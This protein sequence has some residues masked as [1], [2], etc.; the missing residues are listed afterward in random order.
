M[1]LKRTILI[2][3]GAE[4]RV[5]NKNDGTGNQIISRKI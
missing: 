2:I 1:K 3:G 4:D 5:E